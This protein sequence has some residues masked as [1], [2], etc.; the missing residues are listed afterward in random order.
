MQQKATH[1]KRS[2]WGRRQSDRYFYQMAKNVPDI[3]GIHDQK[4]QLLYISPSMEKLAGWNDEEMIGQSFFEL[5]HPNDRAVIYS[6]FSACVEQGKEA[7]ADWRIRCKSGAYSWLETNAAA[8]KDE[9]D[10][11]SGVVFSSR[12]ITE[13]K[14]FEEAFRESEE[15]FRNICNTAPIGISIIRKERLVYLNPAAMR[16]YGYDNMREV[17]NLHW[18]D[19]IA[20]GQKEAALEMCRQR[21]A[22]G[23]APISKDLVGLRKDG[24]EFMCAVSIDLIKLPQGVG[25]IFFFQDLDARKKAEEAL[26]RSEERLQLCLRG[27]GDGI[28]E[29]DPRTGKV[30]FSDRIAEMFGYSATE[31]ALGI[32]AWENLLHP[33]DK[34]AVLAVL[35]DH[36][37]GKSDHYEIELR[38]RTK[39]GAYKWILARGQISGRDDTGRPLRMIAAITDISRL[40]HIEEELRIAQEVLEKRVEARTMELTE[41][42][43][44][45]KLLLRKMKNKS[46]DLESSINASIKIL[47]LPYLKKMKDCRLNQEAESLIEIMETNVKQVLSSFVKN[48]NMTYASLTPTEIQIAGFIKQG[49]K[50]KEIANLLRVAPRTIDSFRYSIRKKVGLTNTKANLK[51]HL[52]SL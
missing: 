1:H 52:L 37:D 43:M 7:T 33:D 19:F 27:N 5:V 12:D 45:L 28:F 46:S 20:P 49:M 16:M 51:S 22:G 44:A 25:T 4:G 24:S 26:R 18:A 14:Q 35:H 15:R 13:R 3:I 47:I 31:V 32:D 41:A 36:L 17:F 30:N 9:E 10:R 39:S 2:G 40:K 29:W 50:T 8:I 23:E 6:A 11:V 21:M 42:N 38:F 34:A 48:L